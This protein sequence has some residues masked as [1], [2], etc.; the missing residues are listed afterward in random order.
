MTFLRKA[1][2]GPRQASRIG[3]ELSSAAFQLVEEAAGRN[4]EPE[5]IQ[6]AFFAGNT[7]EMDMDG[8]WAWDDFVGENKEWT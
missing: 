6:E 4:A 7:Q 2:I 3:G 8:L 5:E 1:W